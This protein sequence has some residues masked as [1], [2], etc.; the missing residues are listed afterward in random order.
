MNNYINNTTIK[1]II[2][3]FI[4]AIIKIKYF[5]NNNLV[6]IIYRPIKNYCKTIISIIIRIFF[7]LI[8]KLTLKMLYNN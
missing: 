8:S 1:L 7:I 3:S 2:F 6:T 4:N 5:D